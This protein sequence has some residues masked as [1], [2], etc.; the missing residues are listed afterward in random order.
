LNTL[1]GIDSSQASFV[2]NEVA[3]NAAS[4]R[5][6]PNPRLARRSAPGYR[7]GVSH[8]G[9]TDA[10]LIL[11]GHGSTK[12]AQSQAPVFQHAAALR[13]RKLFAEVREAFWKQ[14]PNIEA[15]LQHITARRLFI[16]PL[17]ISEGY[18]SGEVIP[19]ALGFGPGQT[20]RESGGSQA[21]Y[22]LPVG[23]HESMTDVLLAR[24]LGVVKASPFPRAPGCDETTLFIAGHGTERNENSRA[25][26]E[27]QVERVR[28]LR[29]YAAVHGLFLEESPL[30]AEYHS[31]A[32][33]RN[34]VVVPYFISEGMH[35][36]E[37][38]PVLLG[39]PETL[40]KQRLQKGQPP[41]R[42]PTE[43]KGRLVWYSPAVGTAPEVAEVI[44]ARARGAAS[45]EK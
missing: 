11:L 28:S 21:Y 27:T 44:L 2:E 6:A 19:R 4:S 15:V 42:N 20:T 38:I 10:A 16:V 26:I 32:A 35:T 25:A 5:L 24:A 8:D 14:E 41:W 39:E 31:L 37:D 36:Q 17:F 13:S 12:N 1:Y 3:E 30:I 45:A 40:I 33:T 23:T 29:R 18:F 34:V 9:F 22:C 7:S 43:K